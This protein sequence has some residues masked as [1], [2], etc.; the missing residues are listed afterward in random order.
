LPQLNDKF[1]RLGSVNAKK[2]EISSSTRFKEFC[3]DKEEQRL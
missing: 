3:I 1:I 2:V